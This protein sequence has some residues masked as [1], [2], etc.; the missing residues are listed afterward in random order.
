MAIFSCVRANAG[1]G[2]GFVSDFRRMNVGITRARSAILVC[3]CMASLLLW[4]E[5]SL[6]NFM[7]LLL[8]SIRSAGLFPH[9]L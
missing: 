2:I 8:H 3:I 1:K 5:G 6:Q 9:L 4:D 7:L